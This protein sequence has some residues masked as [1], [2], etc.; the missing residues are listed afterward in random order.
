[1]EWV[2]KEAV[3]RPVAAVAATVLTGWTAITAARRRRWVDGE[4]LGG[5]R[6]VIVTGCDSGFGYATAHRLAEAGFTIFAGVLDIHGP[7][8]VA[9]RARNSL[10]LIRLHRSN[11]RRAKDCGRGVIHT[12][13][14]DI[15]DDASVAGV[16][17]I[18]DEW[19]SAEPGRTLHALV[20]NAGV[21]N[22]SLVELTSLTQFEE[23]LNVNVLGMVRMTK[24]FIPRLSLAPKYK[25]RIINITSVMGLVQLPGAAGY[26]ASKHAAE[27]VTSTLR[28]ELAAWRGLKVITINPG[29]FA[30]RMV[31]TSEAKAIA[32]FERSSEEVRTREIRTVTVSEQLVSK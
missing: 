21:Q 6:A 1:M 12:V 22:G 20:N 7:G 15:T 17:Q 18:V 25:G 8:A 19:L 10:D 29:M 3:A 27:A 4:A 13:D 9:L 31:E 5:R 32:S 16:C 24:A 11:F 28:W 14:L 2:R 23:M 30:T 26:S